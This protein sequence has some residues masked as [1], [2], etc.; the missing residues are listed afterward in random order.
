V[1]SSAD[2][3]EKL[4]VT[5]YNQNFGVVRDRRSV[6]L[7]E[8]HVELSYGDV[9]AHVQPETVHIRALD[10]PESLSVLEQNYRYDLLTPETLLKKSI[11]KTIRVYRYNEKLGT[12]EA[13]P[14]EVLAVDPSVVLRIDGQVTYDFQGRLA[15]PE[16]PENLVSE[17][18]LVW[19]LDSRRPKQRVEVTYLTR[20]IQWS[21][22]YV[23]VL[24]ADDRRGDLTGWVTLANESGTSY[25]NAELKLVAGDVQRTVR[26]EE[27]PVAD[28]YAPPM[29]SGGAAL[30][31]EGLFEYH[32]YTLSRPTTVR[33]KEQK[34]VSLIEAHDI[35]LVKTLVFEGVQYYFRD[36]LRAPPPPQ[37]V[38]VFLEFR[39]EEKN[40]LGLP[41]PKG[42]VRVYKADKSGAKQF[43]G[44]DRIDHT[45]RD[46]KVRIKLGEAFDVVGE[47]RQLRFT[48][49]G[50]CSSES[51]W[52]IELRNHKDTA[53]TVEV[54][55]PVGGDWEV[56]D[57][58]HP[59]RREDA[60]TLKFTVQVPARGE[61]RVAYRIRSR[62]C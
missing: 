5:V 2:G 9:A 22:D 8:G 56:F 55:E 19:L 10:D 26:Q 54:V 45:P 42:V 17:P 35:G 32:L 36:I 27:V 28:Q 61:T 14:A 34:Q 44:E 50:T 60:S 41:L 3:R 12:E 11:G 52:Q 24:D 23:L 1:D 43:L 31:E 37:K 18:T 51:A 16:V 15:F 33:D 59:P 57:P 29:A 38:G 21:A 39:N 53:E 6:A 47:R 46:E 13:K 62:W 40:Q 20:G 4:T 30:K 25:E 7:G 49:L 58:S 48:A